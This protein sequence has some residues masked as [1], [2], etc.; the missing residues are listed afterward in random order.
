MSERLD[1]LSLEAMNCLDLRAAAHFFSHRFD[2]A[3]AAAER[4]LGRAPD[5]NSARRYLIAS[6][7]HAGREGEA[8]AQTNELLSRD[9][10]ARWRDAWQQPFSPRVDDQTSFSVDC[11][12]PDFRPPD[13]TRPTWLFSGLSGRA[14]P[15]W[16][17]AQRRVIDRFHATAS[18]IDV[19]D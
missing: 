18:R 6:L 17:I 10:G 8:Q 3:I 1:P 15:A 7:V 9:P 19:K 13:A 4:A 12:K 5:Y 11:A 16:R 2:S 14:A